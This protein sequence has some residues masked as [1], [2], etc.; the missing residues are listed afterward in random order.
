MAEGSEPTNRAASA[1]IASGRSVTSHNTNTGR[2]SAGPY[3]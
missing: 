1:S 2:P 3:F